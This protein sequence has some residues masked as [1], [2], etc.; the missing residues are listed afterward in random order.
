[1]PIA[2]PIILAALLTVPAI[3]PAQ[4]AIP[5][6]VEVLRLADH[7]LQPRI[8]LSPDNTVHLV[9]LTGD[10]KHSDV[11]YRCWTPSAKAFSDPVRV[12]SESGSAIAIGTVRGC[13]LAV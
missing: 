8:A 7:P 12:N 13:E 4:A 5:P 10:P 11:Q 2:P 3:C 6:R 9:Y 1:M